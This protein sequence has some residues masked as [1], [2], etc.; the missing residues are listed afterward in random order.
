MFASSSAMKLHYFSSA[1]FSSPVVLQSH[2]HP[3]DERFMV[4]SSSVAAMIQ[5]LTHVC[6][7]K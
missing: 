7:R 3:N 5:R 1:E 6:S 2:A 4:A